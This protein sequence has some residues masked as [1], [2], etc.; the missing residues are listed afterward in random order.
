M[1]KTILLL[2]TLINCYSI[3][4]AQKLNSSQ[5]EIFDDAEFFFATEEFEEAVYLFKQLAG[6][7]PEN[8]NLSYRVGMSYL[9]IEGLERLAIPYLEKAVT[10]TTMKYKERNFDI[11]K[12]PHHAWFYLGNAY[13]IDNRLDEALEAYETFRDIR[14][15]EKNYNVRI[16]ENE[17]AACERAKIIK[18]SPLNIEKISAG[19]NINNG[20]VNY[21]PVVNLR[22][23]VMVFMRK[24]KFYDAV[25]FSRKVDDKWTEPVNITPQVGSDGDMIPTSLSA[26]GTKLLLTKEN[27]FTGKDIYFSELNNNVW[28]KAEKLGKNINSTKD[29]HFASFTPDGRGILVAS[30]RRG[31]AGGSDLYYANLEN[32]G[33][34]GELI[35]FGP[36]INTEADEDCPNLLNE[37]ET[38]YFT[39]KGHFNMGGFDIFYS[40]KD[41]N[42]K[43][44]KPVNI[45][46]PINTTNDNR[47]YQPVAEGDA[48]YLALF[49]GVDNNS[50]EDIYRVRILPRND[51][52]ALKPKKF[53]YNFRIIVTDQETGEKFTLGYDVR[54]DSLKV[55]TPGDN[56]FTID[57]INE[58]ESGKTS[59]EK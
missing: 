6:L 49:E 24:E 3:V 32:D 5:E 31:G 10:S 30:E 53:Q 28:S 7:N 55:L 15:F 44:Q 45:G 51:A 46:F 48:G 2:F 22:E 50:I 41:G 52:L 43:W 57:F 23:D 36:A 39:S 42:G 37:G 38:L 18:D 4:F 26:D 58:Q 16:V 35:S 59:R 34:W 40:K 21:Q 25:M 54:S 29:E 17:V 33:S 1:K 8:T 9:N 27:G 12:A 11:K 13:R 19:S 56:K 14:N 47:F 20:G